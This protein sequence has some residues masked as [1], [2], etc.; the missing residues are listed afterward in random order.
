MIASEPRPEP[1]PQPQP[2]WLQP[3]LLESLGAA[4]HTELPPQPLHRLHWVARNYALAGELGLSDWLSSDAALSLL[5]GNSLPAVG[6]CRASAYGGHQF[7]HWV[8]QLG[9]GRALVLGEI[10][11][12]QGALEVQLKGSGRTPYS[13]SGDGRAVLRSSI[14]EYLCS[15]AMQALG[16]PTTRA[17]A[18]VGSHT[19]VQRETLE[20]AA[21]LTR[22]APCFLRFG[23]FEHF[24]LGTQD[25]PSLH[26]LVD[27]V[28]NR[29]Y[30]ACRDAP[31]PVAALLEA[32]SRR[33]AHLLA[34]WQAVGFCHGVMN[35]DN[36]SI[37][38]LTMDYG[39]F[40]FMDAFDPGHVCNPSD[41]HGRYA[42]FRQPAVAFW[43]LHALAQSLLPLVDGDAD[44]LT[45]AMQNYQTEFAQ[46][47]AQRM[48]AK[49]GL[50][51]ARDGDDQL[52]DNWLRL[53]AADKVDYT[54]AFR[55]LCDYDAAALNSTGSAAVRDLFTNRAGFDAWAVRYRDRLG[56]ETAAAGERRH[57]MRRS[58]PRFVLRN[59]LAESAIQR[60]R[61]GDFS[62]VERLMK[63]LSRP[64]DE[65]PEHA[66]YA[67][68]PPDWAQHLEVSC[69]S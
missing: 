4:F 21:L 47:M 20:S 34:D 29:F 68:I 35:T 61:T 44:G 45:A 38:G 42:Y 40:G 39:P 67:A 27:A 60:A 63:V 13:R 1:A 12:P 41:S 5:G 25:L 10:A 33:T 28:I 49:L 46:A 15:E 56:V 52:A 26:K 19:L 58:N 65:Q 24:A 55:R 11:G 53:M 48:G 51:E 14:R 9:D 16:I 6:R 17:L 30:P 37:L 50:C 64:F 18:L 31:S 57:R 23:H 8:G 3:T 7:G 59:H 22:V 62:E 54:I 36:M 66:A 32:V 43:N 69:S 2:Q